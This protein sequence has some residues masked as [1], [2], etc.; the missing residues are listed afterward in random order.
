MKRIIRLLFVVLLAVFMFVSLVGCDVNVNINDNSN[1]EPKNNEENPDKNTGD[2]TGESTN[3]PGGT[4]DPVTPTVVDPDN[5]VDY[6]GSVKLDMSSNTIKQEV[7]VKTFVD[8]DTTH[9]NVPTSFMETGV[10][11]ARY[12]A[13]NTPESTGKIEEYGKTASNFTKEKLTNASSIIIES[14]DDKLN[15]DSTGGRYLLWVWYRTSDDE[16]YRNLNIEILQNGLAI[17]S[18]SAQ[19]RYGDTCVAAINQ[20][21]ALKLN[22]YSG[23]KDPNFYYGKACEITLK[24]LRTN[25]DYYNGKTVAFEGVVVKD[26]SQTVYVEEYDEELDMYF[27]MTVYYGF[28][29]LADVLN[30]LTVGNRVRVVG[31]VQFYETGGTYQVSGL[32]YRAM[33]PNDPGNV[34]KI[35]EGNSAAYKLVDA[36]T[37]AK[38]KVEI[39]DEEN[40]E[41]KTFDYAELAMSSSISMNNLV[42]KNVYTTNNPESSSD[43]AMT[44]TCECEGE[45]ITI[46]TIVLSV[47]GELVTADAFTNKTINVKGIVD[48]FDGTY[49]I[50]LYSMNDVTFVE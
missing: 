30:I 33:K 44:I 43:G 37:F 7:T 47:D 12:L 24:E 25:I 45:T 23:Q 19:N 34:Q 2:N 5:A 13:I 42:V 18:N 3:D 6:A 16:D 50:K 41:T 15:A 14:D 10:I 49:Q 38:G 28:G 17:A 40:Q 9:F 20:A 26:Y 8:G 1:N 39:E 22:V 27:G 31:S 48:Y 21:K 11:K 29:A 46:R 4:T 35:S 36:K 32:K